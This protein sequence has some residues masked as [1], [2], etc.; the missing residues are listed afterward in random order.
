MEEASRD[1]SLA[2]QYFNRSMDDM[3]ICDRALLIGRMDYL[4]SI[5][6]LVPHSLTSFSRIGRFVDSSIGVFLQRIAHIIRDILDLDIAGF[7]YDAIC[8]S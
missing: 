1:R 7:R 3:R 6:V 2:Q 8:T 5:P 4:Y